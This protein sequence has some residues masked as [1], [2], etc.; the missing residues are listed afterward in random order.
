MRKLVLALIGS[1]VLASCAANAPQR[2]N[3]LTVEQVQSLQISEIIVDASGADYSQSAT[4]P[5]TVERDLKAALEA[6]FAR[7]RAANGMVMRVEVTQVAIASQAAASFGFNEPRMSGIV[8]LYEA[9]NATNPVA[10]YRIVQTVGS[11]G[12][13][14]IGG[15]IAS[16]VN[17]GKDFY[18]DL[19]DGFTG[20]TYARITE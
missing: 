5:T 17:S 10:N 14:L 7:R 8:K 1:I 15:I 11:K 13:D 20:R 3:P 4:P 2:N 6:K 12:K 19:V 16:A 9:S 18:A